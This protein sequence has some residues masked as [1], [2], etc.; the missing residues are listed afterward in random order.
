M[1]R[2]T[3]EMPLCERLVRHA[4]HL[5]GSVE[6]RFLMLIVAVFGKNHGDIL[7]K[8]EKKDLAIDKDLKTAL[9]RLDKQVL[10]AVLQSP[11]MYSETSLE[12]YK[13]FSTLKALIS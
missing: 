12:I 11:A 9:V 7:F 3:I 6:N 4:D 8:R 13:D 10:A 5:R 1:K 2:V